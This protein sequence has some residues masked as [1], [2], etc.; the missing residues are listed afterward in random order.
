MDPKL[1]DAPTSGDPVD[2]SQLE[3]AGCHVNAARLELPQFDAEDVDTWLLMCENLLLDA[4]ISRQVTMFRKVLARLPPER[5]RMVKH[6]AVRHPLPDDC[7]D[8]L[9]NCLSGRLAIAPAER[10]RRLES[11]PPE[12]GDW[13]P[14]Q[15]YGQLEILYPDE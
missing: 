5:F 10:L 12:L 15:L 1:N 4:G 14:S 11:L 7:Y 6:L 9:K 13:K 3:P 8:Q 2:E